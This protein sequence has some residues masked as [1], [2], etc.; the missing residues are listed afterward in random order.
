MTPYNKYIIS[1][2]R[3]IYSI[4]KLYI[5]AVYT[6]QL[7]GTLSTYTYP[8]ASMYICFI[9]YIKVP[10]DVCMYMYIPDIK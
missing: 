10:L 4:I 3:L 1:A 5:L 2:D 7:P 8:K 9:V 6:Y